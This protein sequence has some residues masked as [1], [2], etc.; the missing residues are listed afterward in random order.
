VSEVAD[1]IVVVLSNGSPVA[2]ASWQHRAAAILEGWLLGQAGGSAIA[3]LLFGLANPSGKLAESLPVRLPDTP[4]YLHFPGGDGHVRYGEGIY[5]G[6]RYYDTLEVPVAYPFGH[7]LSYT[8]FGYAGLRCRR[9]GRN[10]F[11]VSFTLTNTGS[12]PGAEIAQLYVRPLD[13]ALDRP[14]HELKSFAKVSL[15]AG[16]STTVS[17]TLDEH[18]FAY[19]SPGRAGWT[20]DPGA[21]EIQIGASARDLRL[22]E[23]VELEGYPEVPGLSA[24][25]TLGEWFAAPEGERLRAAIIASGH[26][27]ALGLSYQMDLADLPAMPAATPLGRLVSFAPGLTACQIE[28]F[29]RAARGLG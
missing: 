27:G 16:G 26:G 28:E 2:L 3:E 7:G 21:A 29:V 19:W 1:R 15:P 17:L 9:I 22:S 6:Y 18:A 20:V 11:E 24:D 12:R 14:V 13:P 8:S 25:S 10:S 23:R 5:V 4:A